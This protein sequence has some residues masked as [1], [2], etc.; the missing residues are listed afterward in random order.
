M[1][2]TGDLR[3]ATRLLNSDLRWRWIGLCIL[4][5]FAAFLEVVGALGVFW[6]IEIVHSPESATAL[7]VVGPLAL[8]LGYDGSAN[9]PIWCSVGVMV[10]YA[11]TNAFLI[12]L[13]SP[14]RVASCPLT[15]IARTNFPIDNV[16]TLL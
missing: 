13:L 14:D 1:I 4:D 6:L 15:F 12:F 2:K 11:G 5:V 3:R 8:K 7:P 16:G 9:W 10:F